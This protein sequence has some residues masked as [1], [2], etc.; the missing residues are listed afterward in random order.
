[1]QHLISHLWFDQEAE[2]AVNLYTTVFENS[3]I[4]SQ[5]VYEDTPSGDALSIEF[6]LENLYFSAINGGPHFK[7]NPA[8]SIMVSLPDGNAVDEVYKQLA[9]GGQ[10]LMPLDSYPFS[11]R[12]AWFADKFGLTWQLMVDPSRSDSN[13]LRPNLLFSDKMC[14]KA[15]EALEFYHSIFEGSDIQAISRYNESE[16]P[17]ERAKINYAELR[18][19]DIEMVLMDHGV[20]GD[21]TFNGAY[22]LM[23]LCGSQSEVDYYWDHLSANPEAEQCGWLQ[24]KFGVSWQVVPIRMYELMADGSEEEN[25]RV[26]QAMLKMKKIDI[27]ALENAKYGV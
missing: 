19:G 27:E 23:I 6:R 11:E 13:K 5:T 8:I 10:D 24:D 20:G 4:T 18:I 22:S 26:T 14:G 15:E 1:M 17:D 2:E 16:A 3:E 21:F 12:Y 7:F 25:N 9:Q